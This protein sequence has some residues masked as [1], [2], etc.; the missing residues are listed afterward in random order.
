MPLLT[1]IVDLASIQVK[2]SPFAPEQKDAEIEAL[3]NTIVNLDGLVDVPVVQQISIDDY[4]LIAGYLEYYAYLKARKINPRLPDRITV[5][6]A[7]TKNQAA[8]RQQLEILQ[9]IENTQQGLSRPATSKQTE[10]DLQ[11]QNFG[12]SL[13]NY[14]QD[15]FAALEQMKTELLSAIE[16]NSPKPVPPMDAFNRILEPEVAYEVQRKLEFLGANKA[17]KIVAQLQEVSKSRSHEPF[18]SFSEI[19]DLLKE[20]QKNRSVRLISEKNMLA[21]MDRWNS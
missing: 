16:A 19:L 7:D 2:S 1:S 9:V 6:I 15:L 10:I 14:N 17:K 13:S 18:H 5:F 3:A 8:I 11:L 21:L 20:Q 12:N 4:E